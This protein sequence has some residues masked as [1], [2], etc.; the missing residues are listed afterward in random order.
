MKGSKQAKRD[1]KEL[2]R[3]CLVNDL[4]DD[5]K[6][7]QAVQR[8]LQAKPRGYLAMLAQFQRLVKLHL[9]RRTARVDSA[10]P[11]DGSRQE[12]LKAGL[13]GRYGTG[14]IFSFSQDPALIGGLRVQVGCDVYDGSVRARLAALE[15]SL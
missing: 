5:G 14:L 1:A 12:A 11:M 15:E 9:D 8:V 13:A 10:V 6:T 4:L 3:S 7:R 2:F